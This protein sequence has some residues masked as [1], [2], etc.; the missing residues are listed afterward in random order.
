MAT[1]I[2]LFPRTRTPF[3]AV[4]SP[5]RG[6]RAYQLCAVVS[7]GPRNRGSLTLGRA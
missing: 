6:T 4:A 5:S 1:I 7:D 2:L 3:G